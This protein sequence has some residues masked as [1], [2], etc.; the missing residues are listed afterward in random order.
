VTTV[1]TKAPAITG[2]QLTADDEDSTG[3]STTMGEVGM[4]ILHPSAEEESKNDDDWNRH[5]EQPESNS[6][7]HVFVLC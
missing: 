1:A 7:K 4:V 5:A 6:T 3:A 2:A